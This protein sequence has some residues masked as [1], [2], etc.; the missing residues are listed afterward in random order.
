MLAHCG[1][2]GLNRLIAGLPRLCVARLGRC[3]CYC[4][5]LCLL[6]LL[7]LLRMIW[8]GGQVQHLANQMPPSQ[9][10]LSSF[11]G[12]AHTHRRISFHWHLAS[13]YL[14][15]SESVLPVLFKFRPSF[16]PIRSSNQIG[17]F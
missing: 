8:Q 3:C 15:F 11:S 4:Y 7:L 2:H 12:F 6:L 13:I 1:S 16:L 10:K 14:A 17:P 5:F 9:P